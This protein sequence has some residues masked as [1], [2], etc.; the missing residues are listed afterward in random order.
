MVV[1][2]FGATLIK[3][4]SEA[5]NVSIS[6][7]THSLTH[8]LTYHCHHSLTHS[9]THPLTHSRTHALTH[10]LTHLP[11]SS[12][13][14]PLALPTP[15]PLLRTASYCFVLLRTASYCFVLLRTAS[16]CFVLQINAMYENHLMTIR[17]HQVVLRAF[18]VGTIRSAVCPVQASPVEH[19]A[20]MKAAELDGTQRY[21]G[22]EACANYV[23]SSNRFQPCEVF[24]V[25]ADMRLA[26]TV[27]SGLLTFYV[28]LVSVFYS[29][30][31]MKKAA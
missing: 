15:H 27:F 18:I 2:V 6:R 3:Y 16:Y 28:T 19:A 30:G 22:L 20:A 13:T 23:E 24:G 7:L 8:S 26:G 14:H 21:D 31:G 10:S 17:A 12:P 11:L 1:T 29:S 9:L 5:A 4:T 25:R